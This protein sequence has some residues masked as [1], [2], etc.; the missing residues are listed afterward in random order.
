MLG[1]VRVDGVFSEA[2]P[3]SNGVRQGCIAGPILFNLFDI[4]MLDD[5]FR[6]ANVG[7]QIRLRSRKLFKL[8]RLRASTKVLEKLIQ[9]LLYADDCALEAHTLH[10]IQA[11]TDSFCKLSK[12]VWS[13]YKYSENQSHVSAS[14]RKSVL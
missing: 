13:H 6:N 10:D 5:A 2:F 4:V 8:S 9:E 12:S 1:R 14:T 11:L 7:I 3:I